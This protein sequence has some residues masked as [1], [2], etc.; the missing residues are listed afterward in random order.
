[1]GD[2]HDGG[3]PLGEDSAK[4]GENPI[5]G[6][7]VEIPGWFVDEKYVG[8]VRRAMRAT[9]DWLPLTAREARGAVV[10]PFQPIWDAALLLPLGRGWGVLWSTDRLEVFGD[11][12]VL[13]GELVLIAERGGGRVVAEAM[14]DGA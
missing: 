8:F 12:G 6:L 14:H 7:R 9:R 4:E 2:E 3:V 10:A 11:S 13:A 5:D 1:M